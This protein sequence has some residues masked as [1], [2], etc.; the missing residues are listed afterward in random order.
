[1]TMKP[2]SPLYR[3]GLLG[4]LYIKGLRHRITSHA[5][6][7]GAGQMWRGTEPGELQQL[8]VPPRRFHQPVRVGQERALG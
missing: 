1:M 8:R 6:E 4:F 5:A 7:K 3:G 2:L